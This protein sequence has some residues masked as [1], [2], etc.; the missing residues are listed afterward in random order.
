L[1]DIG[2]KVDEIHHAEARLYAK[3]KGFARVSDLARYA[4]IQHMKKY[5]LRAAEIVKYGSPDGKGQESPGAVQP[6]ASGG[7]R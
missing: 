2:F 3:A 7:K 6:D 4:L 1:G 5:P